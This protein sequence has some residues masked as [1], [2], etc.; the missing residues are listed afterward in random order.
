M[1]VTL[2]RATPGDAQA[3]HALISAHVGENRL[4]PRTLSGIQKT[5]DRWI[6]AQDGDR[7]VGCGTLASFGNGLAEVRSLVETGIQKVYA[8]DATVKQA[9]DEAAAKVNDAMKEWNELNM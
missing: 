3:I 7:L 2:R 4:L 1:S 6:V 5:I 9:L 8:G